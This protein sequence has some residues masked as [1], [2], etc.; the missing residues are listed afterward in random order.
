[1]HLGR[2]SKRDNACNVEWKQTNQPLFPTAWFF[3][4]GRCIGSQGLL[5]TP[6]INF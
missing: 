1:M 5:Q 6:A 2:F 4:A 3:A